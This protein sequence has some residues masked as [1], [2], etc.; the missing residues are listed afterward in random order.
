MYVCD[1]LVLS[2]TVSANEL[3]TIIKPQTI[4]HFFDFMLQ[5]SWRNKSYKAETGTS[6]LGMRQQE[7][8]LACWFWKWEENN[9][10]VE[11]TVLEE[12]EK[13]KYHMISLI[14]E[15]KQSK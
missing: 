2:L 9:I 3:T 15:F 13:D 12:S 7:P 10:Q 6:F 4:S 5:I 11:N 8:E 1:V 14:C